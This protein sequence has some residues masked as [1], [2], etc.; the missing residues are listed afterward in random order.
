MS[1]ERIIAVIKEKK[2]E[3]SPITKKLDELMDEE[4][5]LNEIIHNAERRLKEIRDLVDDERNK[6]N[7]RVKKEGLLSKSRLLRQEI[8]ALQ[9]IIERV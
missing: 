7:H 5:E 8:K 4:N 3:L 9:S 6:T 2:A 1:K